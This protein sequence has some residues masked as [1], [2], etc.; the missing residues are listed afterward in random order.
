MKASVTSKWYSDEER[1]QTNQR[2]IVG[3]T[4]VES[5]R[6]SEEGGRGRGVRGRENE[7]RK[8]GGKSA[9]PGGLI[10][11]TRNGPYIPLQ[12]PAR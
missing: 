1:R 12:N 8:L 6:D 10:Y 7:G 3:D 11:P 4:D 9:L 2:S 5:E